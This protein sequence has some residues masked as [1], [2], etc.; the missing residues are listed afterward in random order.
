MTNER[1]LVDLTLLNVAAD[2][3]ADDDKA[4]NLVELVHGKLLSDA[5]DAENLLRNLASTP[6]E[7]YQIKQ[8]VLR[9]IQ[10]KDRYSAL[11][12]TLL[13]SHAFYSIIA[14]Q[15]HKEQDLGLRSVVNLPRTQYK[16]PFIPVP[17]ERATMKCSEEDLRPISV[18]HQHPFVGITQIRE[19][20]NKSRE[21]P[22]LV[23]LD[24]VVFEGYNPRLY[25]DEN[26]FLDIFRDNFTPREW[27]I[28]QS[29]YEYRL[30]EFY[31]RWSM[32]EAYT[33]A[34]GLEI[35]RAHV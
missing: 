29:H 14:S 22:L 12:S 7:T 33:K 2:V 9:Y 32:K 18:S 19:H 8:Q 25:A 28:I 4:S 20:V 3:Q 1:V 21:N 15:R 24:I 16:K 5:I 11:T 27:A 23:G 26:E 31:I 6:A 17:Y 10:P 35:G 34:L 13:K 30:E